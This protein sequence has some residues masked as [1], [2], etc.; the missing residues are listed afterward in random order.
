MI[1]LI[2][3]VP[4]CIPSFLI[5]LS[6]AIISA[7]TAVALEPSDRP[8]LIGRPVSLQVQPASV[9]L[10]GSRAHQQLVVTGRYADGAV[11]DLTAACDVTF[12]TTDVASVD[13][14]GFLTP[15]GA[16]GNTAGQ[17]ALAAFVRN[18]TQTLLQDQTSVRRRS[19]A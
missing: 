19:M 3:R 15:Q 13:E 8:G 14:S 10:N 11:R 5:G 16:D 9:S 18:H 17:E 2:Q 7:S 12:E 1:R 4:V 6:L